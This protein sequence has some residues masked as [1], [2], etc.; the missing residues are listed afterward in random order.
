[1]ATG[2]WQENLPAALDTALAVEFAVT[3]RNTNWLRAMRTEDD[4]HRPGEI[5]SAR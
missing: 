4:V 1:M 3:A 5:P 2:G